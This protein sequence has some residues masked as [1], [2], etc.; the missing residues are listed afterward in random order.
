MP[1]VNEIIQSGM[2]NI[3]CLYAGNPKIFV[4]LFNSCRSV[5]NI[6]KFIVLMC[7]KSGAM[8]DAKSNCKD[9]NEW[10]ERKTE[11]EN[12]ETLNKM[13]ILIYTINYS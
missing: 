13:M 8:N 10:C 11:K 4:R 12:V 5:R 3:L 7:E 6:S 2:T 9:F 1:V